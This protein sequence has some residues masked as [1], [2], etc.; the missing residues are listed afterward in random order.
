MSHFVGIDWAMEKHDICILD[1]S[2]AICAELIISDDSAGYL[3]LN[4]VLHNYE[5]VRIVLEK[6][7]GLL[8]EFL[9]QQGWKLFF[10]PPIISAKRRPRR[11]KT[12]TGDAYL[13]ANLLRQKDIE[14]RPIQQHSQQV[15]TLRQIVNVTTDQIIGVS[16]QELKP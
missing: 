6:P 5:D 8:I 11:S 15:Q 3:R 7:D 10:L 16:H 12:D 4:K 13:L 1:S 14:C 2:S 9:I